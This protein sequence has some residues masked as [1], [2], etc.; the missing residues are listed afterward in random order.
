M[1]PD[2]PYSS[3]GI[4]LKRPTPGKVKSRLGAAVGNERAAE[5]YACFVADILDRF[6]SL[7]SKT[8]L[9]HSPAGDRVNDWL[10]STNLE[11]AELWSQPETNLG[12]RLASFFEHA[13]SDGITRRTV[14]IGTDSPTLPREYLTEAFDLLT[15]TDCVVGPSADGG[16]YLLGLRRPHSPL[17]EGVNWSS[18]DVLQQTTARIFESGLT[19]KTLPLWYDVDESDNLRMLRGHLSALALSGQTDL[20]QRTRAWIAACDWFGTQ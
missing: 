16:Y 7:A 9:A 5:L 18:P 15:S 6:G 20:P 3:L 1:N 4:F 17:F 2:I 19:M 11:S 13:F 8:I 12:Q 14:V 10:H